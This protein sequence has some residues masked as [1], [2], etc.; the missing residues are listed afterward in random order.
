MVR[1]ALTSLLVKGGKMYQCRPLVKTEESGKREK[2]TFPKKETFVQRE[3]GHVKH[4]VLPA[5]Y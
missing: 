4:P 3:E 5:L 2:E 1:E